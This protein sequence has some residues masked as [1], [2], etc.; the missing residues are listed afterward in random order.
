ML[1]APVPNSSSHDILMQLRGEFCGVGT[2]IL[3]F[4]IA[5]GYILG[6]CRSGLVCIL[7]DRQSWVIDSVSIARCMTV[8]ARSSTDT[9][10]CECLRYRGA[11]AIQRFVVH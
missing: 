5:P 11:H 4:A 7:Y 9:K 3:P 6:D 8:Q 10:E 1:G 2:G